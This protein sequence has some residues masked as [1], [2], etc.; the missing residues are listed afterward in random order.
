MRQRRQLN[1]N[2]VESTPLYTGEPGFFNDKY[3]AYETLAKGG[4]SQTFAYGTGPSLT[5]LQEEGGSYKVSV[6]KQPP[7]NTMCG[8][9]VSGPTL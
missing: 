3:T 4:Y 7:K 2:L 1:V 6:T 8:M 9:S 5:N